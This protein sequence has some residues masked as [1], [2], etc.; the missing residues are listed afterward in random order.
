MTFHTLAYWWQESEGKGSLPFFF[1]HRASAV[2][3]SAFTPHGLPL[4]PQRSAKDRRAGVHSGRYI[5]V[6]DNLIQNSPTRYFSLG[7][8]EGPS[9]NIRS[10]GCLPLQGH[11]EF[12]GEPIC[13]WP[14]SKCVDLSQSFSKVFF[15]FFFNGRICSWTSEYVP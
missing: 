9:C 5:Y 8:A 10:T 15:F 1:K 14:G 13:H 7:T 2:P 11:L 3:H 6:Q 4:I 12:Q